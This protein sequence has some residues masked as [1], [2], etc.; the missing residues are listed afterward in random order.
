MELGYSPAQL[1]A[2][3]QRSGQLSS[4]RGKPPTKPYSSECGRAPAS[5]QSR[6]AG[7]PGTGREPGAGLLISIGRD[8][9]AKLGLGD[10]LLVQ[11]EGM[12]GATGK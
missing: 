2:R 1:R 7:P 12:G 11:A 4:R 10:S 8:L 6:G 9:P 5:P 3:R